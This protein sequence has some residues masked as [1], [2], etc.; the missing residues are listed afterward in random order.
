[1]TYLYCWYYSTSS[2]TQRRVGTHSPKPHNKS[3]PNMAILQFCHSLTTSVGAFCLRRCKYHRMCHRNKDLQKLRSFAVFFHSLYCIRW[4]C[5]CD[6]PNLPASKEGLFPQGSRKLLILE[7]TLGSFKQEY[8]ALSS[9]KDGKN[10]C[11]TDQISAGVYQGPAISQV[12]SA[13]KVF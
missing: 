10:Q 4:Q 2:F 12:L 3:A 5:Q 9:S 8:F 11:S 13:G 6:I 1:M 7:K